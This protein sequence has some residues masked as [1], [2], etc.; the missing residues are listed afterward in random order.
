MVA[1]PP[2]PLTPLPPLPA[3]VEAL[4][5]S[6]DAPILL[7]ALTLPPEPPGRPGKKWRGD[8]YAHQAVLDAAAAHAAPHAQLARQLGAFR[9]RCADLTTRTKFGDRE[10]NNICS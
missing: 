8:L 9:H 4:V 3:Q 1:V 6:S 7:V 5:R 2:P 10:C